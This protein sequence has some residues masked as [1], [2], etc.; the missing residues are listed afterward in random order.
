[1]SFQ[2]NNPGAIALAYAKLKGWDLKKR[3]IML[4]GDSD[5]SYF[6]LASKLHY[7]DTGL[8]LIGEDLS[9][10]CPGT[11]DQGGTRGLFEQYPPLIEII[12]AD[13]DQNG[14]TLF[15]IIVLIDN[16]LMGRT[17]HRNLLHQYRQLRNNGH[18]F[19]LQRVFPRT[20]SESD[21][22]TKQIET[23]NY[24]WK[25]I[26][27]EIE[28]LIDKGLIEAF[29][30]EFPNSISKPHIEMGGQ[31]HYEFTTQAKSNLMRFVRAYAT[32]SD[33]A[34]LVDVI[35]SLRFYLGLPVNGVM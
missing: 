16:D 31:H 13:T 6:E 19:L 17:L 22:L 21:S 3:N 18:V 20:T 9:I 25:G 12:R 14:K 4:E 7:K 32:Q 33:I 24:A 29:I 34:A 23:H 1:M 26:N 8:R 11:G 10:F 5:V 27:T 30:D 35:K 2:R 28:D 15:R